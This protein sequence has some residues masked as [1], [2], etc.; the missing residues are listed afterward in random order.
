MEIE[1]QQK[2]PFGSA[3]VRLQ[4]GERFLS[5]YGAMYRATSNMDID[6]TTRSRGKGGLLR[7]LK[8]M[9]AREAFFLSTYT[10]NDGQPGEVA[11]APTL[12]GEVKRLDVTPA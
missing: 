2:P 6:V 3:V 10:T 1:I 5:E 11:L 8:R 4:A 12:E 9:L 7:G